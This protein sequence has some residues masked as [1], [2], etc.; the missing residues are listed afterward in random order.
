MSDETMALARQGFDAW[1]RGDFAT[2]EALLA[3]SVRW[4]WFEP[5]DWDCSSREDVMQ[6]VRERYDQGFTRGEL[7]F[8][9]GGKDSV[10]VVAHPAAIGGEGWPEET[11][12][13][14]TFRDGKVVDMQD[15]RAK[16]E[17]LSAA[18]YP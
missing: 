10:I 11:A 18:H 16:D 7:E 5:G 6:T 13:V 15:F 1:R 14:V 8:L 2:I 3:P 17:A 9:D 12:T 4:R